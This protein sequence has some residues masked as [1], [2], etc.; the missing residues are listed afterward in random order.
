MEIEKIQVLNRSN[1]W[2]ANTKKLIQMTL[3]IGDLESKLTNT[4]NGFS[5]RIKTLIP[6]LYTHKNSEKE[7][8]NSVDK[9]ICITEV[10]KHIAL[11]L[12]N[13][14]GLQTEYGRIEQTDKIGIYNLEFSYIDEDATVYAALA[15]VEI[16]EA[17]IKGKPYFIRHDIDRLKCLFE[18]YQSTKESK[19]TADN[20]PYFKLN[21]ETV[22]LSRVV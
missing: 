5:D 18:Q 6:S 13:L 7:F 2:N 22:Q 11:E 17:L 9:G 19:K 21:N 14:A 16:V 4:I 1:V 15:S 8:F 3:N 20:I 12:Q 10:I